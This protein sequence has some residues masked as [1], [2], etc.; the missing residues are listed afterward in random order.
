M[1]ANGISHENVPGRQG[2]TTDGDEAGNN[3]NVAVSSS[4]AA[5]ARN[6]IELWMTGPFHALGL[7]RPNLQTVGFGMCTDSATP[8]WHSGA[9][10]DV[11]HGLGAKAPMSAPI[12]FPGDGSTTSLAKFVTESPDP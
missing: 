10:L 12:L 1:L 2:Y 4:T 8:T 7:L 5:T 3:C 11:L 9:T 6:H